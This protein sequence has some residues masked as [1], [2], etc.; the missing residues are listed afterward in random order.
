M[1]RDPVCGMSVDEKSARFRTDYG[2]STYYFCSPGCL[3][4]F[5]ANPGKYAK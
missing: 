2:G 3:S 5:S 1:A 4:N